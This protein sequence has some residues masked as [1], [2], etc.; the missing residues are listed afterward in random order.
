[1]LDPPR[2]EVAE[3]I[4]TC[5]DAGVRVIVI[6]GDNQATAEAICKEIGIFKDE[7]EVKGNSFIGSE[8]MQMSTEEQHR[9]VKTAK[10]VHLKSLG[11]FFFF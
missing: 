5:F 10:F 8:F 1:M 3:A 9:V 6:T 7:F 2:F 4:Q 11:L